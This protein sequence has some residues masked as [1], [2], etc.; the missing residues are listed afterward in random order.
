VKLQALKQGKQK[1]EKASG[2][3]SVPELQVFGSKRV[4]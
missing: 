4:G 2:T 1:Q 3:K